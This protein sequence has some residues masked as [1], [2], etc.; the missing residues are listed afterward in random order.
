MPVYTAVKENSVQRKPLP[1]KRTV[2]STWRTADR[3]TV[4]KSPYA[5]SIFY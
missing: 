4:K 3:K 5:P 1:D 2:F